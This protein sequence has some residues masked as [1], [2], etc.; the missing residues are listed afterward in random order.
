MIRNTPPTQQQ[1]TTS[2]VCSLSIPTTTDTLRY[3][4][5]HFEL[6]LSN[7]SQDKDTTPPRKKAT[8]HPSLFPTTLYMYNA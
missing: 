4:K 3:Y 8:G 2:D 1:S 5:P 7:T 6:Q